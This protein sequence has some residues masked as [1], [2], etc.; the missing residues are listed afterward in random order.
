MGQAAGVAAAL[1]AKSGESVRSLAVSDIQN[2]L[3]SIGAIVP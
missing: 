3:S 1:S 2:G